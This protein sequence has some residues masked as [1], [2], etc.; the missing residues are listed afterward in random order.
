MWN[1][2]EKKWL[3]MLKRIFNTQTDYAL[4]FSRFV[5]GF[6]FFV[7]G[8]Q[9]MLG[10]FGGYGLSGSMQ[11]FTRQLGVPAFFAFL[12]ISGQFFGGLM[13]IIGL[14]GRAAALATISIMAVAVAKVHWQFG[15]FM[16][17]FGTQ[18]GEG[19]EYHL[20]AVAL[21][22]VVV[23]R[24]SGALS[25][26]RLLARSHASVLSETDFVNVAIGD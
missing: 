16:N 11:F 9:L 17:W 8:G 6:L 3:T 1:A 10:W 5:L 22:L 2:T 24:G 23:L 19:F 13:L 20:L 25:L 18:K 26:D 4:T 21:G 12:A 14:A 7:H 15:L